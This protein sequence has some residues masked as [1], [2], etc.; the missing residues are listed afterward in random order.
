M[1]EGGPGSL[2]VRLPGTKKAQ[3]ASEMGFELHIRKNH[4][5]LVQPNSSSPTHP[6]R[7]CSGPHFKTV[8]DLV[9]YYRANV[10]PSHSPFR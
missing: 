8:I 2:L 9:N 10:A 7:I 6:F 3:K 5:R 4:D 1:G